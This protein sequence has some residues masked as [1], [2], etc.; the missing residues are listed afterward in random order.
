MFR[1]LAES[2]SDAIARRH[3]ILPFPPQSC[4]SFASVTALTTL[5]QLP[6]CG[7]EALNTFPFTNCP[8]HIA[9]SQHSRN[10]SCRSLLRSEHTRCS[11]SPWMSLCACRKSPPHTR[12]ASQACTDIP[13]T[14][15]TP[16]LLQVPSPDL[17]HACQAKKGV[18]PPG[19]PEPHLLTFDAIR[20]ACHNSAQ[21][22]LA[23]GGSLRLLQ[24]ILTYLRS[25]S[26]KALLP[27]TKTHELLPLSVV[28][29]DLDCVRSCEVFDFNGA[30]L[31]SV[32]HLCDS[33]A[34]RRTAWGHKCCTS[35]LHSHIVC[36]SALHV[37]HLGRTRHDT[38]AAWLCIFCFLHRWD[39]CEQLPLSC[40]LGLPSSPDNFAPTLSSW[41]AHLDP[42]LFQL[43]QY[44]ELPA[45]SCFHKLSCSLCLNIRSSAHSQP[46]AHLSSYSSSSSSA[47][48]SIAATLPL[49]TLTFTHISSSAPLSLRRLT[50]TFCSLFSDAFSHSLHRTL[51]YS[52]PNV[53]V[54]S[55]LQSS[56][57]RFNQLLVEPAP[58]QLH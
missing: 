37:R 48:L 41:L 29:I 17:E 42:T 22:V 5:A 1:A 18:A 55:V 2:P 14:H 47:T 34:A 20:T 36:N 39:L 30:R 43:A 49:G 31:L 52:V 57:N 25:S 15:K 33:S 21:S 19:V 13:C 4:R 45:P 54:V 6:G 24:A 56:A 8:E 23:P 32:V 50:V 53:V 3:K 26:V 27:C 10:C 16:S 35:L 11:T 9:R 51:S 46:C 7:A 44:L 40:F 38:T 12:N 58:F 28:R